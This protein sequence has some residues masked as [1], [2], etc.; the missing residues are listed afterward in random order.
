MKQSVKRAGIG[1]FGAL[2]LALLAWPQ[3]LAAQQA[4]GTPAEQ[5]EP[6]R[7][8][9]TSTTPAIPE[10]KNFS[11]EIG[12]A[13][14]AFIPGAGSGNWR[15]WDSR[16][17]YA[18][19]KRLTPFGGVASLG[20]G[21]GW[22]YSLGAGAYVT[23][24]KWFW[25]V[26]GFSYAPKS[27]TSFFIHRRFDIAGMLTVPGVNGLV[28]SV[29]LTELPAYKD[30]GAGRTIA[31]G[32]LYYWRKFIFSG[33]VNL[34]FSQPGDQHSVSGQFGVNYGTQGKYFVSAGMS[35]GNVAYDLT[36]NVPLNVRYQT[37]DG[38]AAY[39]KWVSPHTGLNFRYGYQKIL[40]GYERHSMRMGVFREF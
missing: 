37:F 4:E 19:W 23:I 31:L 34:N 8:E 7:V 20:N 16:L 2:A 12:G 35:G 25:T 39:T 13:Y 21:F 33:S 24:T 18:G 28:F 27:D 22:Q 11:L 36:A 3:T 6:A 26:G 38:F 40:D 29:G 14:S 32:D 17:I 1:V 30:S 10:K 5:S 9:A 15:G